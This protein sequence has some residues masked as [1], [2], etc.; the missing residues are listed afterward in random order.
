MDVS[1]TVRFNIWDWKKQTKIKSITSEY[2]IK[3]LIVMKQG[4]MICE[5]LD[6][7]K[8]PPSFIELME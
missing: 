5:I 8:N 2:N 7:K 1:T 4:L 6:D 3:K